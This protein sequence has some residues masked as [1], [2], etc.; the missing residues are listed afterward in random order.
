MKKYYDSSVKLQTYTEGEKVLVYDPRKRRGKFAKWQV[1]WKGP[2]MVE[3]RLN[4]TNYVLRKTIKSK[5]VVV[6]VDHMHK[7]PQS[8]ETGSSN[9]HTHTE[10]EPQ[11]T[12]SRK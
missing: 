5:P 7:L 10:P 8:M 12:P 9:P 1:C 11:S 6:H 3:R 4:D 2:V